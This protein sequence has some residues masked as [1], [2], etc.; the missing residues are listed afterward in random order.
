VT[1][2]TLSD[3]VTFDDLAGYVT[4]DMLADYATF[5]DLASY[6]SQED[7]DAL[8]TL[9]SDLS[10]Q[11]ETMGVDVK[12]LQDRVSAL[13][14]TVAGLKTVSP[15]KVAE[16]ESR[17]STLEKKAV[18]SV[19]TNVTVKTNYKLGDATQGPA[20]A[21]DTSDFLS[22][23][24]ITGVAD[25]SAPISGLLTNISIGASGNPNNFEDLPSTG[26]TAGGHLTLTINVPSKS[27]NDKIYGE[28]K[29]SSNVDGD[30]TDF[31]TGL[32]SAPSLS[33]SSFK[34]YATDGKLTAEGGDLT[35]FEYTPFVL[36]KSMLFIAKDEATEITN[37]GLT[38]TYKLSDNIT[39]NTAQVFLNPNMTN[40]AGDNTDV[41]GNG[42]FWTGAD[43]N[44]PGIQPIW[45]NRLSLK[46]G[47]PL[48]LNVNLVKEKTNE[49]V[50][51]ADATIKLGNITVGAEW[52]QAM[53]KNFN[54]LGPDPVAMK[55]TATVPLG[56]IL[57]VNAGY[58][59][60]GKD[61]SATW[62]TYTADRTGYNAGITT[63]LGAITLQ[64][65]YA[66]EK[67]KSTA[68]EKTGYGVGV[69]TNIL[70]SLA[71]QYTST[72]DNIGTET[73]DLLE[74][75]LAPISWLTLATKY[76]IDASTWGGVSANI[77][78]PNLPKLVAYYNPN[79]T[80]F[81]YGV[82]MPEYTLFNF[83]T[84]KA[85]FDQDPNAPSTQFFVDGKVKLTDAISL[86]GKYVN[87]S[88]DKISW[89]A[90]ATYTYKWSDNA[91]L[92]VDLKHV[93]DK[94]GKDAN[95]LATTVAVTF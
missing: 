17:V 1:F 47:E 60:V 20:P 2:D 59:D 58:K 74:A 86:Y 33:I 49:I 88:D 28:I 19:T 69:K 79:S 34:A 21:T 70:G 92:T 75:S 45:A 24:A 83:L 37:R 25:L 57:T 4:T 5:D 56:S 10:D 8:K 95:V 36:A 50:G 48:A 22:N 32:P 53:D 14:D 82:F 43:W 16:L 18:T 15:E 29:L 91:N 55:L 93:I 94:D 13:E 54:A 12:D 31:F 52:E 62:G 42:I 61:Y 46:F 11:F 76:D 64:A 71:V 65:G 30:I 73:G 3:Y 77:A 26:M 63:N 38:L 40:T 89:S 81:K 51:G 90:G 9:V 66:Y 35:A 78:I 6:V 39:L 27:G 85:Q 41:Y 68:K 44:V 72:T 87:Y 23:T 80:S 7:F 84:L 67:E